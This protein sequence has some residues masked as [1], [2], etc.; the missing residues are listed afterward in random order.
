MNKPYLSGED[1]WADLVGPEELARAA[2]MRQPA[3]RLRDRCLDSVAETLNWLQHEHATGK[4]RYEA[5]PRA[6]KQTDRG[7]E[8]SLWLSELGRAIA[9]LVELEPEVEA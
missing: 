9:V 6:W 3:F 5:Q 2:A 4:R 8:V 7:V 1:E